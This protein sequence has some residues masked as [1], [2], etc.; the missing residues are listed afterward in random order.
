MGA[1]KQDLQASLGINTGVAPPPPG[2]SPQELTNYRNA[3]RSELGVSTG[4]EEMS[5]DD[6]AMDDMAMDDMGMEDMGMEDMGM[7]DMGMEDMAMA[8]ASMDMSADGE[9]MDDM[10][11][12]M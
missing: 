9:M 3:K 6:M 4:A 2:A 10:T 1:F 5:T 12:E 8:D 7:E 11:A